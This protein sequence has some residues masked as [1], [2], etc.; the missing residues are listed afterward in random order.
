MLKNKRVSKETIKT[1]GNIN[2]GSDYSI[3]DLMNSKNLYEANSLKIL[4]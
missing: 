2:L 3:I 1:T 4:K